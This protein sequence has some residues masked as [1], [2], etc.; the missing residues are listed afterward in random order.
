[1]TELLKSINENYGIF[2]DTN[3]IH[4]LG[5]TTINYIFLINIDNKKYIVKIYNVDEEKQIKNSL[6]TQKNIFQ[7]LK[8]TADVLLNK[9][10]ELYTRYNDK[11]YAI[12]EYIEEQKNT[13]IDIIEE[14]SKN[15]YFLHQE[16]KKLDKSLYKNKKEYSNSASIKENMKKSKNELEK[17]KTPQEVKSI[18]DK[19]LNKRKSLLEKYRCEYHPNEFQVIHRDV[20]LGNI[21]VNNNGIYFID[22]DYVA[23]GDLLFEI[24]S[25]AMLISDFVIERAKN[26]VNVYNSY[27]KR[28]YKTEEIY[29]NLLAYYVQ[30]DFPINLI[31]K[32]ENDALI[33][34]IENRIKCL[35]FCEKM[36]YD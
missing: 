32:V 16:L 28:K 33:G 29:Q 34:F 6:Y 10:N 27:L 5:A 8:I 20:R 19:L 3:K 13:K 9:K 14:T 12:Q 21:I 7:S 17:N 23:Y 25:A 15:L 1:M 31:N 30:S 26:F 22:F 4:K 36:L 24:G 35:D 2:I 18:F 11:L